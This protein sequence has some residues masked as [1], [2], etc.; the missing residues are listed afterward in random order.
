MREAMKLAGVELFADRHLYELSGGEMQRVMLAR[1]LAQK[2]KVIL[3]DEPLN[4]LDPKYQLWM[5]KLIKE[6]T[7]KEDLTTVV[8]FHDLNIAL[9]FADRIVLMK[10]GRIYGVGSPQ[11]V[12]TPGNIEAVFVLKANVV[13]NPVP[14]VVLEEA[15]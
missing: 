2:P 5:I 4:N 12:I 14:Y 3:L 6:L 8:V 1:V 11:E 15:L 10:D 13:K 9:R 7:T